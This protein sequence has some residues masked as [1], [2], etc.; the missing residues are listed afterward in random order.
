MIDRVHHA[1]GIEKPKWYD[2]VLQGKLDAFEALVESHH[3]SYPFY[4]NI[5]VAFVLLLAARLAASGRCIS[6]FDSLDGR[7]FLLRAVYWAGSRDALRHYYTQAAFLL[8]TCEGD[9]NNDERTGF[10]SWHG[11]Q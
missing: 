2:S 3:R 5:V 4:A 11:F 1:N 8:G 6:R 10:R 7:L 9:E